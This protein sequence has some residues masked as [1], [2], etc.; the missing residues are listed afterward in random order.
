MSS[1]FALIH[2]R[3][4]ILLLISLIQVNSELFI[5]PVDLELDYKDQ[6]IHWAKHLF[7]GN[8]NAKAIW[9]EFQG[10]RNEVKTSK[11][12]AHSN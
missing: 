9:S 12:E 3:K 10:H 4:V 2:R 7:V 5:G 8:L 1:I 6:Y 11:A